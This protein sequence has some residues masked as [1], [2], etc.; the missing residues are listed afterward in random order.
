MRPDNYDYKEALAFLY[1]VEISMAAFT[2][3]DH[4]R[5]TLRWYPLEGKYVI[6][7]DGAVLATRVWLR[8]A[9]EVWNNLN[10]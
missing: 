3:D 10:V 6:E 5:Y 9:L 7:A 1:T 8:Q 2:G 4:K